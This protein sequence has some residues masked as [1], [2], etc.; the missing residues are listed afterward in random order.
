[1]QAVP[2]TV[3]L[4]DPTVP[5]V[6]SDSTPWSKLVACCAPEGRGRY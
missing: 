3:K 6:A 2:L 5:Q 1:V 4:V